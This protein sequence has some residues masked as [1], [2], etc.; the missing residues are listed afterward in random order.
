MPEYPKQADS[1][2]AQAA[3]LGH[4]DPEIFH[5]QGQGP[6]VAK[7]LAVCGRCPVTR[8]CEQLGN[9]LRASGIW[10]GKL[11]KAGL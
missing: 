7:A 9:E 6:V 10:G 1:W 2:E 5:P 8:Q 4:P 3:C 11:R